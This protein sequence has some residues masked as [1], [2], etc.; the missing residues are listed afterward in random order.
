MI[1]LREERF[2][3]ILTINIVTAVLTNFTF[4]NTFY[5]YKHIIHTR[6]YKWSTYHKNLRQSRCYLITDYNN[7]VEHAD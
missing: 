2:L 3:I 4:M 6:S 7:A 1:F 5:R